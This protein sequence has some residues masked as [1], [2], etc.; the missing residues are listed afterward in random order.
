M[1][2]LHRHQS[3][4]S[5]FTLAEVAV[6]IVIIGIGLV[7]I[8]QGLNAS[9][10]TAAHTHN[11]KLARDLALETLGQVESGMFQED[12]ED[13]L[14]GSYADQGYTDFTYEIV[15][16]DET[17]PDLP[18]DQYNPDNPHDS[19]RPDPDD[20]DE[21]D[22]EDDEESDEPYEKVKIRVTFPPLNDFTNTLILEKWIPWDQVYGEDEE[23][24]EEERANDSSGDD[25]GDSGGTSP[26]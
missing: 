19:W 18:D 5:A 8:L 23:E 11:S 24:E 20:F 12:I 13:Y 10:M 15:V 22:D 2:T 4:R 6:T 14:N 7:L 1:K 26:R 3:A 25:S 16:G 9:K 21:D 17:F